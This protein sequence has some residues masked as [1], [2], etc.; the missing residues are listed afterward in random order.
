MVSKVGTFLNKVR[1][2]LPLLEEILNHNE[3]II[4]KS[5]AIEYAFKLDFVDSIAKAEVLIDTLL[6]FKPQPIL[7]N[8]ELIDNS[9]AIPNQLKELI[10]WVTKK[11]H[12]ESSHHLRAII[13]DISDQINLI[14]ENLHGVEL[15]IGSIH[16]SLRTIDRAREKMVNLALNNLEAIEA[17]VR[18]IESSQ[19]SWSLRQEMAFELQ[20]RHISPMSQII[21]VSGILMKTIHRCAG[22]LREIEKRYDLNDDI[23]NTA[24]RLRSGLDNSSQIVTQKHE[25]SMTQISPLLEI[26][27]NLPSEVMTGAIKALQIAETTGLNALELNSRLYLNTW[28]LNDVWDDDSIEDLLQ[29]I[30]KYEPISSPFEMPDTKPEIITLIPI[31]E[32]I[33]KIKANRPMED[34]LQFVMDNEEN[35]PLVNC[36]TA[37]INAL[38]N[39]DGEELSFGPEIK[40]YN[41]HKTVMEAIRIGIK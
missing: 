32:L 35:V 28:R 17:A 10:L 11:M 41:K 18:E 4:P 3:H 27:L 23:R 9:I 34:I 6:S 37:T 29:S 40:M 33:E 26:Y 7:T 24:A 1:E 15:K 5:K 13:D 38:V 14:D 16:R 2:C 19:E 8:S 39:F 12:I 31:Y 25:S 21:D 22:K 20:T 30:V 36:M